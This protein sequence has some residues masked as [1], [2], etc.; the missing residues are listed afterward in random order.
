MDYAAAVARR[1]GLPDKGRLAKLNRSFLAA[2]DKKIATATQAADVTG[3][4][5]LRGLRESFLQAG[6]TPVGDA[7]GGPAVVA[8]LCATYRTERVK[9]EKEG[10]RMLEKALERLPAHF[11]QVIKLRHL[12]QRSVKETSEILD[13]KPNAVN[14]LFHRAQQRLHDVLKEMSYFKP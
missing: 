9:I 1:G 2:I 8:E 14:V 11:R 3:V 10:Y 4:M 7:Q 5:G 6:T 12:E 13:M